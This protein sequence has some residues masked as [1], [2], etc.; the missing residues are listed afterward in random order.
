MGAHVCTLGLKNTVEGRKHRC[1]WERPHFPF[2][3]SASLYLLFFCFLEGVEGLTR[4][5]V[6]VPRIGWGR[7]KCLWLPSLDC[8]CPLQ[9]L[10]RPHFPACTSYGVPSQGSG[11]DSRIKVIWAARGT[12][13][14]TSSVY[15][16]LPPPRCRRT[17]RNS[18]L[19]P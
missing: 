7:G 9:P 12:S 18:G 8:S 2:V 4:G 6:A 19:D 15:L 3:G 5:S 10:Y 17:L 16:S 1:P 14:G 11:E 13:E